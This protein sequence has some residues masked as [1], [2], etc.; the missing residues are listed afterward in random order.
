MQYADG[1]PTGWT[2]FGSSAQVSQASGSG[3]GYG[4]GYH[5]YV[6]IVVVSGSATVANYFGTKDAWWSPSTASNNALPVTQ[7]IYNSNNGTFA[8]QCSL[9]VSLSI[10]LVITGLYPALNVPAQTCAAAIQITPGGYIQPAS[11][12]TVTIT[13]PPPIMTKAFDL[14]LGSGSK[15]AIS[16]SCSVP[17]VPQ[18]W[19]AGLGASDDTAAISAAA[20][21]MSGQ[22]L[23]WPSGTYKINNSSATGL[24][25]NN[26]TGRWTGDGQSSIITGT[27]LTYST[28]VFNYPSLFT[29]EHLKVTN[30]GSLISTTRPADN[31]GSLLLFNNV[32]DVTVDDINLYNT[33]NSCIGG[34]LGDRMTVSRIRCDN[35][36]ANPIQ[37][38]NISNLN[39]LS[40]DA[41]NSGDGVVEVDDYASNSSTVHSSHINIDGVNCTEGCGSGIIVASSVNVNI[42]NVNINADSTR[43]PTS[44][45]GVTVILDSN[46]STTVSPN[47]LNMN[48][49]NISNTGSDVAGI[50]I[51]NFLVSSPPTTI[52]KININNFHIHDVRGDG[53]SVG[54]NTAFAANIEINLSN[55][56]IDTT[57]ISG[58]T[59]RGKGI[60]LGQGKWKLSNVTVS[61]AYAQSFFQSGASY[62]TGSNLTSINPN[63][64]GVSSN[65]W[66]ITQNGALYIKSQNVNGLILVDGNTTSRSNISD[67]YSSAANK[68]FTNIDHTQVTG[69]GWSATTNNTNVAITFFRTTLDGA[70]WQV[71]PTTGTRVQ[72][73][74]G[75]H[76]GIAN[77]S[78]MDI[79]GTDGTYYNA[80]YTGTDNITR[81]Q[82]SGVAGSKVGFSDSSQNNLLLCEPR[83]GSCQILPGRNAATFRSSITCDASTRG[84][85]Q[86]ATDLTSNT[87]G[88]TVTGGGSYAGFASC[89]GT[90]WVRGL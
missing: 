84:S 71:D 82:S 66:E 37:L 90:N 14:S 79:V 76:I 83:N 74:P 18:M 19:G 65:A 70:V 30:T 78:P 51:N 36:L 75:F 55:G 35:V 10:P 15:V 46:V 87:W 28:L 17:L 43:C 68:V 34:T 73:T 61:N 40:I 6:R 47:W 50:L 44:C 53:L 89:N 12:A 32:A 80:L 27:A 11:A 88:A 57:G 1:N 72:P 16:N 85:Y 63:T 26:L 22:S 52:W 41:S 39:I 38:A 86:F 2:S 81:I 48:N 33:R 24:T 23:H 56:E 7:V 67:A 8:S 49:I 13:C 77:N 9:A 54:D 69:T 59:D 20:Y 25:L 29:I 60:R 64:G 5:D 21:A 45:T 58:A 31:T 3:I 42:A 62:V 4:I